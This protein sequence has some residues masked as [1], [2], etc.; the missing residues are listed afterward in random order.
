VAVALDVLTGSRLQLNSVV[1]YSAVT[2]AQY[3]GLAT[4]GLGV[5]AAGVLVAAGC[6]AQHV[7]RQWRPVVVAVLGGAAVLVVGSPYLGSDA[8]GA[9]ALTA[10]VC[11]AAAMSTGGWLTFPRVAWALMAGIAVTSGFALLD[12]QRPVGQRGSVGRFL[13]HLNDGT[14]RVV[15]QP[16]DSDN[17]VVMATSPLTLLVFGAG[18]LLFF[19]LLRPWGGLKRLFGLYPAVRAGLAGTAVATL[20]AGPME[21]VGFNIA[22]AA[23]ATVLPLTVLAALRV[24]RHADE[25]T[26]AVTVDPTGSAVTASTEV[27]AEPGATPVAGG[28][29]PQRRTPAETAPA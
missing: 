13:G 14:G 10:G 11:V 6:V 2:G 20:I 12:V 18:A 17:V 23:A 3:S 25:R 9:V 28:G 21:G 27:P 26:P 29:A 16:L 15:I 4:V 22:G 1:G 24:L 7:H 5:F 19:A 8:A